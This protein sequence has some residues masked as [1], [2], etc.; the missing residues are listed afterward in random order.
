MVLES[1]GSSVMQAGVG[2]TCMGSPCCPYGSHLILALAAE[3]LAAVD[4]PAH[5]DEQHHDIFTADFLGVA[6]NDHKL[7][8]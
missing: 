5:R 7:S 1:N 3:S 8:I 2:G 6:R 4:R